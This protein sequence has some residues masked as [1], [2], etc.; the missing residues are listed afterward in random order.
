[1]FEDKPLAFSATGSSES[2]SLVSATSRLPF[3]TKDGSATLNVELFNEEFHTGPILLCIHGVCES[4]ETLGIQALVS[5]AKSNNV[6]VAVLE[7]EGHGLSSGKRGV[8]INF[9]RL[10][11]HSCEFVSHV[12]SHFQQNAGEDEIPYALCGSS[13]GGVLSIYTADKISKDTTQT[14]ATSDP[15]FLPFPGRFIG[16][17]P[18]CPAVGV[19][20][21]AVPDCLTVSALSCLAYMAPAATIPLTPLEDPTHYN[22]PPETNRNYSGHWPLSTSKMLL[23]VTS[24]RVPNDLSNG[25]LSLSRVPSL[26]VIAGEKDLIVPYESVS[27]FYEEVLPEEKK[28]IVIPNA[29]HDLLFHR[30][31]SNT[32]TSEIFSWIASILK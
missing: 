17:V 6:R 3:T 16:L 29:G 26:L 2:A 7:C 18:I 22:C 12:L 23:D 32:A 1:M 13:M 31:S 24:Q 8:C 9:D 4:A 30:S 15:N 27:T 20:S 14:V 19:D 21:A 28:C 10:V 25:Q 11:R 5:A